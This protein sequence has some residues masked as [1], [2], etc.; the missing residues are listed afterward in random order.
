MYLSEFM[1]VLTKYSLLYLSADFV[2]GEASSHTEIEDLGAAAPTE[3][4]PTAQ[5]SGDG[6]ASS[7]VDKPSD[8][9]GNSSSILDPVDPVGNPQESADPVDNVDPVGNPQESYGDNFLFVQLYFFTC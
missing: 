1:F 5:A 9:D 3:H 4:S 6:Q 2:T 8:I 7:F